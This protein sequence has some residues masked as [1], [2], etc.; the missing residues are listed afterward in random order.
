MKFIAELG[1]AKIALAISGGSDSMALAALASEYLGN[2]R[3]VGLIVDHQLKNYGVS[4][5]PVLVQEN[6]KK[7]GIRSDIIKLSWDDEVSPH[8]SL[9]PGKIMV[10]SRENRYRALYEACKASNISLLMTGH[11]LEDDIVTMFFRFSRMS[12]IDGLAGMK[13]ATIFPF[14]APDSDSKFIL[15]PLLTVPKSQLITTCLERNISW[16]RDGSNDDLSFR[17]NECLQAL[18]Q[19]QSENES[20]S[21]E[22]LAKM[23]GSFKNHRVYIHDKGNFF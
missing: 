18:I 4:E 21:T 5:E 20:I 19:L 7:L 6:L 2:D 3:V 17:R 9:I 22:A 11:N 14:A 10:K 13:Q 1:N 8:M 12:G 23:L 16:T 15:R